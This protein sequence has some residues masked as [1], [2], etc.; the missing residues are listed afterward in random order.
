MSDKS[1]NDEWIEPLT[2]IVSVQ[3]YARPIRP[4]EVGTEKLRAEIED[5][6]RTME[7]LGFHVT[8]T[9]EKKVVK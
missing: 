4:I 7:K 9:I 6:D 5:I 2:W 3:G 1:T 8:F